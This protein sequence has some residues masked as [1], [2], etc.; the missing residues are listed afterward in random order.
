MISGFILKVHLS[1][2]WQSKEEIHMVKRLQFPTTCV[3]G[4]AMSNMKQYQYK[5]CFHWNGTTT[6]IYPYPCGTLQKRSYAEYKQKGARADILIQMA[7][8]LRA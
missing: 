2:W 5:I 7:A 6:L 4:N 1:F 3:I 8:P